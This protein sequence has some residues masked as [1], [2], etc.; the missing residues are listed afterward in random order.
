M[1]CSEDAFYKVFIIGFL[2]KFNKLLVQQLKI[3]F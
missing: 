2:F 1:N 3:F